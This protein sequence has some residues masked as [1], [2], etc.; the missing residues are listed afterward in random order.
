MSL[1]LI[2]ARDNPTRPARGA[3][4]RALPCGELCAYPINCLVTQLKASGFTRS[5]SQR[6]HRLQQPR[7]LATRQEE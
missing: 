2:D 6:R 4:G 3:V 1:A 7:K 5:V